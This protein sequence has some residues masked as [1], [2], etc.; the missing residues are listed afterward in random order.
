[1]KCIEKNVPYRAASSF[2]KA[3]NGIREFLEFCEFPDE[4]LDDIETLLVDEVGVDDLED[5][6]FVGEDDLQNA[7]LTVVEQ[8]R[9]LRYIQE[10]IKAPQ[11]AATDSA[12]RGGR[13]KQNEPTKSALKPAQSRDIIKIRYLY[14]N[15]LFDEETGEKLLEELDPA[16]HTMEDIY[17][18]IAE[19]EGI[20][21]HEDTIELYS[22][23][24]YPLN[25]NQFTISCK[26]P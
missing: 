3:T 11:G 5:L 1:M 23:E 15:N 19:H 8:N 12:R 2:D 21:A 24:G 17:G 25:V 9:F 7:G 16:S 6:E 4:Q 18:M 14:C 22:V 13:K 26:L 10:Q 20:D